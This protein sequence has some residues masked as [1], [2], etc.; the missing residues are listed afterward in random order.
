[1]D[2]EIIELFACN[3]VPLLNGKNAVVDLHKVAS[4]GDEGLDHTYIIGLE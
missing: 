2:A 4:V 3:S 1:M